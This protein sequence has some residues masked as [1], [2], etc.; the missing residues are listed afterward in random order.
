MHQN[1]ILEPILSQLWLSLNIENGDDLF[2]GFMLGD[3]AVLYG[4]SAVQSLISSL[5]SP[6]KRTNGTVEESN[7]K[8]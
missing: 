7:P 1:V 4:S 6:V 5:C 8:N 2:P 3:F